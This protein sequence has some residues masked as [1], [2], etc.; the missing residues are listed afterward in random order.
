[1]SADVPLEEPA[2]RVTGPAADAYTWDRSF[3]LWDSYFAVIWLATQVFVLGAGQPGRPLRLVAAA[4]LVPLIPL[5]LGV[6][7]RMLR[8]EPSGE[9]P[10]LAYLA[11]ALALFL[12]SAVL[13]GE[14]RLLT[15][16]LVPQ[17]F[18]TLRRWRATAA[19]AV[20]TLVPVTG[21]ALVWWPG[22][23]EV[24]FNALFAVVTFVFSVAVGGWV[25]RVVEQSQE[26]AELIAELDASRHELAQ[27]SAAHGALA[28][29]ERMAREIHDTLAQGFTSLLMLVQAVEAELDHDAPRARRH[30]AL[31][32]ETARQNLAEA[33]A[34]VAG[35]TPADLAGASLSDALHRLARRHDA[36][37][38]VTGPVRALPAGTEVVALRACQEALAN[39]RKHAGS[40]VGVVVALAYADESVTVS[41]RDDGPG[42][43]PD[44]VSAGYGLAGLRARAAEVGG[45]ARVH[46]AP[47]AGTTVT[48]RLPVPAARSEV[49]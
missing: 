3:R 33:R 39:A 41:V 25:I 15:F 22:G 40:S 35:G 49:P 23:W 21:W 12:P 36:G 27:L 44:A 30:L 18:M 7:R 9:G 17:C 34:L 47:D 31:M 28:E 19:A 46:S 2:R 38:E 14:T 1:M 26:R 16:A 37:L 32:E 5:Y 10:A 45:T 42:F 24:F 6:G 29:R 11:A 20:I 8:G 43:D 4:L 13:V 48:V